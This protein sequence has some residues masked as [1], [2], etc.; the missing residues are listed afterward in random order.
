MKKLILLIIFTASLI[1][2]QE[3]DLIK[4]I[5]IKLRNDKTYL[6]LNYLTLDLKNNF[7]SELMELPRQLNR[8]PLQFE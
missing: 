1:A 4:K 7:S 6:D 3:D 8:D 2:Q 5:D